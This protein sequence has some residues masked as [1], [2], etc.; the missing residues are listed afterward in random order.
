[1]THALQF[2]KRLLDGNSSKA[3]LPTL[4]PAA[5]L[6]AYH[7]PS[8]PSLPHQNTGKYGRNSNHSFNESLDVV[9]RI[10]AAFPPFALRSFTV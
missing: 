10:S 1:M 6:I 9:A 3:T 4:D 2:L 5:V 8:I 7:H